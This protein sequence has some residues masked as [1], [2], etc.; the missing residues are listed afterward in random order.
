M[1][2]RTVGD[3]S[4]DRRG[5]LPDDAG[6]RRQAQRTGVRDLSLSVRAREILGVTGLLGMGPE[7]APG[8]TFGAEPSHEDSLTVGS[9]RCEARDLATRGKPAA[10]QMLPPGQPSN[11]GQ[12]DFQSWTGISLTGWK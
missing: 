6:A 12:H 2:G 4:G 7:D 1:V 10:G 5:Q 8:L 9:I 11:R 3:R